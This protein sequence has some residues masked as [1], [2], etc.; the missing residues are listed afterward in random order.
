VSVYKVSYFVDR[1]C[2]FT[3]RGV[4][5]LYLGELQ[6]ISTA[7]KVHSY[8]YTFFTAIHYIIFDK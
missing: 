6:H 7:P 5:M 1:L 8:I 3:H 2:I 4:K